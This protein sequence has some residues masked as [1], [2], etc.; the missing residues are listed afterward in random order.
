MNINKVQD[1]ILA[2]K[3]HKLLFPSEYIE[4]SGDST[5]IYR[6]NFLDIRPKKCV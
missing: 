5:I 3:G 6:S 2:L 4:A 1:N